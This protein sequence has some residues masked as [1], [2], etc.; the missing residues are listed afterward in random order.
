ML[1]FIYCRSTL[2]TY[3][4]WPEGNSEFGFTKTLTRVEGKKL[5]DQSLKGCLQ[6]RKI[7]YGHVKKVVWA[8]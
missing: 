4:V 6:G 3:Y 5:G 1:Y 8:A 7:G 2:S